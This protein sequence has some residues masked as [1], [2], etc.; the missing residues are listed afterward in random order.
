MGL[1]GFDWMV[2]KQSVF[3]DE[4]IIFGLSVDLFKAYKELESVLYDWEYILTVHDIHSI[5]I[6][7]RSK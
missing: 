3:T 1:F 6:L 4:N 2:V 7:Y 5:A